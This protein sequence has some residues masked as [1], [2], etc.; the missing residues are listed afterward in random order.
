MSGQRRLPPVPAAAEEQVEAGAGAATARVLLQEDAAA[1][2]TH[3]GV[4]A[5]LL[6]PQRPR[7]RH[8]RYWL[9]LPFTS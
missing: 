9:Q 6:L 1:E 8:S 5:R 3:P 4:A 7:G 2:D